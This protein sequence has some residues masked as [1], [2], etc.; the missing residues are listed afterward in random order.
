MTWSSDQIRQ[1][2]LSYFEERGHRSMSSLSLIPPGDG[3]LLFTNAGM[4]Q[5]KDIF[6]GERE[7]D[8]TAATTSQKCLRV[9]GKH[10]DL[11]NV[12]RTRRHHTF[13]E[14]LGNF[15]FGEY[16]KRGAIE[17]AWDLLVNVYQLPIEKLYVTVHPDDDDARMLWTEISSLPP[18]RILDDPENFWSMGD[19]GPCGPCSEIHYDQGK[20]LSGGVEVEFG[21]GSDRYLEI[22]NLVFMQYDRDETGA[23]KA[24]PSPSIDTGM[25]LER[26]ASLLQGESSNYHCDLFLPLIDATATMAGISYDRSDSETDVALRVIAD[27]ARSA[28]FLVADGIY[29]ENEGRGYV[30]RRVMRRAMRFGYK[31]GFTKPFLVDVCAKVI[32]RMSDAFPELVDKAPVIE[33]IVRLEEERFLRTLSLGL[34]RLDHAFTEFASSK[35]V[36]GG[37]AFE[38]Y[39]TFGFPLDLTVQAAEERGFQVDIDGF[40]HSME[41]QR[42]RGRASWKGTL[43][44]TSDWQLFRDQHGT[45]EFEGY[46]QDNGSSTVLAILNDG[47][48]VVTQ[49]TPFY[50]ESGGQSG[51]TGTLSNDSGVFEVTDTQ[52]PIDGVI[53]HLGEFTQGMFQ[54]GETVELNVNSEQRNR[55]RK[56]H[57][58]THLLHHALR[59]TLGDHV[60]QRGSHVGPDRLR[61][62]FSHFGPVTADELRNIERMVN[63]RILSNVAVSTDIL[64]KEEAV[65]CG[66]VAFFGDK[67]GETVRMLSISDSIELCGGTHVHAT[68]DIGMFKVIHETSLAAG[69]R[70]IEA[71][72]GLSA[73]DWVFEQEDLLSNIADGLKSSRAEVPAKIAKLSEEVS[74]LKSELGA[75]KAKNRSAGVA[76]AQP[77]KIG[78]ISAIIVRLDGVKGGDLRD[79]ADKARNRIGSGAV[80]LVSANGPKVALLVAFTDDLIDRFHAGRIVGQIAQHIGGRGGGKPDM[81]QAGGSNSDGIPAVLN[82]FKTIISEG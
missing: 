62:D 33:K 57:S 45:V 40:N 21:D 39:D 71:V 19:T 38:L 43:S 54:V 67:Y 55:T 72:T 25:G 1:T 34:K 58:A 50:A 6:T 18:E 27:H 42:A 37:V 61:F 5:F 70:R 74:A 23:L 28:T 47:K 9:S 73:L 51:D 65:A 20:E 10:N 77:V 49:N 15:S 64:S 69:V 63:E 24:L 75:I 8:Y 14:M 17:S 80:L 35:Q 79:M 32:E 66:A 29:P 76:N 11:E 52:R 3:T 53:I 81:A 78:D 4:V 60:K 68:G 30:V 7:V 26:I 56:N 59:V 46:D 31:L 36:A 44:D 82:A 2:F 12:G 22:W 41:Q 16:F 48:T 13:F